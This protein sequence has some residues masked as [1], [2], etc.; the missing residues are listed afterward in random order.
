MLTGTVSASVGW[1]GTGRL[2]SIGN[3]VSG[4]PGR[5]EKVAGGNHLEE[6]DRVSTVC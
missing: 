4:T 6:G 3:K 1:P 2:S 5:P